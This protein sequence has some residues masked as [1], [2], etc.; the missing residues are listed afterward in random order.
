MSA[1]SFN[2]CVCVHVTAGPGYRLNIPL[3]LL[4][5]LVSILQFASRVLCTSDFIAL[6][7]Y[8]Y[9]MRKMIDAG[10]VESQSTF[11]VSMPTDLEANRRCHLQKF[12][13]SAIVGDITSVRERSTSLLTG[14]SKTIVSGDGLH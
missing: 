12:S 4:L 13:D 10:E 1:E 6:F 5:P 11:S 3:L 8:C 7:H 14:V 9:F 2:S